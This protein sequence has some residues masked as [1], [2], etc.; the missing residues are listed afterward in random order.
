MSRSLRRFHAKRMKLRQ[1]NRAWAHSR[2]WYF[3]YYPRGPACHYSD[4]LCPWWRYGIHWYPHGVTPSW[5]VRE[6]MTAPARAK[7][8]RVLNAIRRGAIDS[9]A[10]IFP[11]ARKPHIYYW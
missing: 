7:E 3:D 1:L 4:P 10:G 11:L 5:W 9:D 8:R 2:N 6:F